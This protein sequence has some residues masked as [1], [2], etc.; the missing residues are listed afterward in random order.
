MDIPVTPTVRGRGREFFDGGLIDITKP[1]VV[2]VRVGD[3]R[4]F[5]QNH[6]GIA[7][8]GRGIGSIAAGG[9]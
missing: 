9:G 1:V 7:A 8:G 3:T 2:T 4:G 6:P 5:A